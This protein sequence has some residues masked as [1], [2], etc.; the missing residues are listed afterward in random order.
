M[1]TPAIQAG[2]ALNKVLFDS[3]NSDILDR[4]LISDKATSEEAKEGKDDSKYM[5]PLKVQE[6]TDI[7]CKAMYQ[8]II[9][10]IFPTTW[11][12][13]TQYYNYKA[14][15]NYGQWTISSPTPYERSGRELYNMF[16][17]DT[18]T[19][20]SGHSWYNDYLQIDCPIVIIP[21]K[22]TI[23]H[24]YLSSG[25]ISG[26]N[27]LT[28]VWETIASIPVSDNSVTTTIVTLDVYK[29]Y[30]KLRIG[31]NENASVVGAPDIFEFSIDSGFYKYN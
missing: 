29:P 7:S 17:G 28:N 8:P 22:I 21:T 11:Q 15:N 25:Y 20:F 3:I 13:V 6:I 30:S 27:V 18:S 14:T 23:I 2:T 31:G 10:K 12:T 1:I 26:Y 24:M 4:L 5:T 19:E 16:D 9:G